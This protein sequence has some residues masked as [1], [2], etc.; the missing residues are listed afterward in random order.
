MFWLSVV[1]GLKVFLHWETYVLGIAYL[2]ISYLPLIPVMF[3]NNEGRMIAKGFLFMILQ[4][5]FTA[6]GT[7]V[8]VCSLFPI[9]LGI[10]DG[11]SWSM[12]WIL[13]FR[14]PLYVVMIIIVMMVLSFLAAMIPILGRSNSFLILILGGTVL[15]FLLAIVNKVNPDLGIAEIDL[16]PGFITII[17]IVLV[18]AVASWLGILAVAIITSGL[19]FL[20]EDLGT[21]LLIPIG[22]TFGFIPVF[23]YGA[24]LG[25]Q[26]NL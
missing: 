19:S 25:F 9:I 17:G 4:P 15:V 8:L 12:P 14:V 24:W 11:A 6:V 13:I 21:I 10:G 2:A 16:I 20:S 18:S 23:I 3:S 5:I 7:F 22:S 1:N 26:L